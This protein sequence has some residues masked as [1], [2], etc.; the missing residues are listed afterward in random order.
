[1]AHEL[2]LCRDDGSRLAL[3]ETRVSLE[4]TLVMHDVG[5]LVLVL[6]GNT[7]ETLYQPD[8]RL[9]VWRNGQ[10]MRVYMIRRRI[11]ATNAKGVRSLKVVAYD[12]AYL[13]G[14]PAMNSGR[15]VAYAA[16]SAQADV[17]GAADNLM[18]EVLRD[19]IGTDAL[20][21]RQIAST[22]VSIQANATA[23]PTITKAFS[24]RNVLTVLQ[25]LADAA[26]EAGTDVFWDFVPL[27]EVQ[28]EFRTSTGQPGRDHSW[29]T[30]DPP[31]K[32]SQ[33][34]GS[35]AEPSLDEDWTD[36][37]TY[38]Y[39]GGQGEEA[40]RIIE[41]AE[42][43]VRSGRSIFGRRERF[44]DARD[45]TS[46]AGVQSAAYSGLAEGRPASSFSGRVVDTPGC[47]LGVHWAWGDKL[48]ATYRG[49]TWDGIVKALHV[50]VD[51]KGKETVSAGL[52]VNE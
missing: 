23:G 51:G 1:M 37:A 24:R 13:V 49:R 14:N 18:K 27:S 52:E 42:D 35:L 43:T 20:T 26:H 17:S 46:S 2:W 47:A 11:D 15:I 19:N 28:W 50:T 30:G 3:V 10:L 45:E 22:Y 5:V 8:R 44:V 34:E 41:T 12:A 33:E 48:T 21:A 39:A 6:P 16:A 25:D 36:E 29:T 9:A 7:D 32:L 40:A 38:V 31:V 4:Y